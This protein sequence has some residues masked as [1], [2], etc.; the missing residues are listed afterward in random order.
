MFA[1]DRRPLE[2]EIIL[3][4]ANGETRLAECADATC[5]GVLFKDVL[6]CE[7]A[8]TSLICTDLLAE[9]DWEF[10]Q[11]REGSTLQDPDGVVYRLVRKGRLHFLNDDSK[12]DCA[13]LCQAATIE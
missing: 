10:K 6:L 8:S 5:C 2:Q 13:V 1:L 4:T 7:N 3:E 9:E 12:V 11:R